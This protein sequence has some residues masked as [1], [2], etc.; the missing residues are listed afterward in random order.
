MT[1]II[2]CPSQADRPCHCT[3]VVV[4]VETVVETVVVVI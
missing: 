3:I 4:V 1:V 2:P